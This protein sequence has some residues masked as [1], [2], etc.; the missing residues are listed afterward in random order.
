MIG[1]I[2][3]WLVKLGASGI[4]DKVIGLIEHRTSEMTERQKLETQ[5]TVE[6]IRGVVRE[7]EVMADLNKAKMQFPWFW[8][9]AALFLLPLGFWWTAVIVDSVFGFSW[10]VAN[11][12]TMQM[13]EWAGNMIQWVFYVGGGVA[14][15]R[16]LVK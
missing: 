1:T 11:L 13:Q 16:A 15:L 8:C 3:T 9:F 12:P 4:V 10:D 2:V 7:A 14:G 5:I 6:Y